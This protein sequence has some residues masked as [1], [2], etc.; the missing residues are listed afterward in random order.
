METNR[1]ESTGIHATDNRRSD[2]HNAGVRREH[3][4][5]RRNLGGNR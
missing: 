4:R 5:N 2:Y 3:R 1:G